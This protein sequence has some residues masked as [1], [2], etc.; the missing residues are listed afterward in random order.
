MISCHPLDLSQLLPYLVKALMWKRT[1]QD[2]VHHVCRCIIYCTMCMHTVPVQSKPVCCLEAPNSCVVATGGTGSNIPSSFHPTIPFTCH[3][4]SP[5][6]P[7]HR[8]K[9]LCS[10][11]L[12]LLPW[13]PQHR[14]LRGGICARTP[15]AC[16]G[17]P[18]SGMKK[19]Q[20]PT[21]LVKCE[22]SLP[23]PIPT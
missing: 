13:P 17:A 20:P 21:D 4:V 9:L 10:S 14:T 12:P 23:Y 16:V 7:P 15:H 18:Q 8:S 6:A 22:R 19:R 5:S 11:P 3:P 1:R 2:L